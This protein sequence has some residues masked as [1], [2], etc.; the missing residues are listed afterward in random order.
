MRL[1]WFLLPQRFLFDPSVF[2][3]NGNE[4]Y[5]PIIFCRSF[6]QCCHNHS[7]I[8]ISSESSPPNLDLSLIMIMRIA[9]HRANLSW[10]GLDETNRFAHIET[11][12]AK[13]YEKYIGYFVTIFALFSFQL[14]TLFSLRQ[15]DN[16]ITCSEPFGN[17]CLFLEDLSCLLG[18]SNIGVLFLFHFIIICFSH[19]PFKL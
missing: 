17:D 15:Y 2:E 3:R 5:D 6:H 13:Q 18:K 10:W 9:A 8:L 4:F 16:S 11:S 19:Q 7:Q 14:C 12:A 1:Y